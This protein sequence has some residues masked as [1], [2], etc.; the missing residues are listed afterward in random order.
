MSMRLRPTYRRQAFA[1]R[2]GVFGAVTYHRDGLAEAMNRGNSYA[3]AS[4]DYGFMFRAGDGTIIGTL[5]QEIHAPPGLLATADTSP[6]PEPVKLGVTGVSYEASVSRVATT[7]VRRFATE[8][9]TTDDSRAMPRHDDLHLRRADLLH[10]SATKNAFEDEYMP[11]IR[12]V[13]E[14]E[15]AP[16]TRSLME[17]DRAVFGHVLP[18]T[19]IYGHAPAIQEGARALDAGIGAAGR[20]SPQLRRL[21]N[22]RVA[23]IVGCPF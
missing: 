14:S 7:A 10:T 23:S 3:Q 2:T 18:G 5:V 11:R 16:L 15:A 12:S 8:L 13:T 17:R 21:M 9:L 20:I 22:L 4:L 6:I 19:G 1:A